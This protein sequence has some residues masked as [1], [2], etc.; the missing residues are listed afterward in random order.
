M[1][2][3]TITLDKDYTGLSVV[4]DMDGNEVYKQKI[5]TDTAPAICFYEVEHAVKV[6]NF[7]GS[8]NTLS[9]TILPNGEAYISGNIGDFETYLNVDKV[10]KC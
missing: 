4:L 2:P 7:D 5:S 3:Y 6:T 8:M 9:F 10:L 1:Y